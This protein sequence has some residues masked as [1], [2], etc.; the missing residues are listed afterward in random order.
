ME[1]NLVTDVADL[2]VAFSSA[3]V[4]LAPVHGNHGPIP[5]KLAKLR[6]QAC[7]LVDRLMVAYPDWDVRS[8]LMRTRSI[9]G[10]VPVDDDMLSGAIHELVVL[11]HRIYQH[12]L[13]VAVALAAK[14]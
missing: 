4:D 11:V 13:E 14:R 5:A 6:E 10:Q 12:E 3:R 7:A 1:A 8:R 2:A 9:Y